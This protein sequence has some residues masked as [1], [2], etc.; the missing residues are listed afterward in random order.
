MMAIYTL[1]MAP[2][3]HQIAVAYEA[4]LAKQPLHIVRADDPG[5][6]KTSKA[7][8]LSSELMVVYRLGRRV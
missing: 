1:N 7:P 5:A 3:P 2:Y 6:H 8:F 4:M